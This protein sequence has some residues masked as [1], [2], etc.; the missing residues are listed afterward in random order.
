MKSETK[1]IDQEQRERA[2]EDLSQSYIIEAAAGT[3]K[4]TVLVTRIIYL[5][6]R[7]DAYLEE[8]VAITFTEKAAAELKVKLLQE[9]EKSLPSDPS[10]GEHQLISEAISDLE[11]MQVTTIHSFCG[12]LLRERPVEAGLD[13]NFEVADGL[14]ARLVQAEIWEDWFE[15]Q[16]DANDPA[17]RRAVL[18]GIKPDQI[19]EMSESL[20]E[21]RDVLK[22]LPSLQ[23]PEDL[24]KAIDQFINAFK[25]DVGSL[26]PLKQ[27]CR[28]T[29]DLAFLS[30]KELEE[31]LRKL[32][33]I[34]DREER[35]RFIFKEI[36]TAS[37]KKGNKTKWKPDHQLNKVRE[38]FSSI[39]ENLV[40][41]KA[42]IA[43]SI[44]TSLANRLTHYIEV[45]EQTKQERNFLD[46]QDLLIFTR[47]MLKEHPEVRRYFRG[48]YKFLLVDE[49][50]DTDP[51]QAEIVFFLSEEEKGKASEWKEVQ[52][53]S[54]R[55]F[56]VGD[57]KQ[58]IYRFRRADIEM[59][60]DAKAR[61]GQHR[62]LTISQNF[63]CAPSLVQVVNKIFADLIKI[64][65]DGQYQPEYVPL[66]FGRKKV[67]VP[68]ENGT[69][70]LYPPRKKEVVMSS[71][72]EC[73]LWESRCISSFIQKLVSEEKWQVW[74]NSDQSFRPIMFKDIAIL[75]RT[76]T[77]LN[78]LEE[79]LRSY[80]VDYRVVGGKHFYKRQEV[81]QLLAVLQAIDNPNDKV[82]LVAA[83]RSPFFGIS[84]EELFMF[85]AG[86]GSLNYLQET[87]GTALEQPFRLLRELHE[88]RNRASVSALLKRVYEETTGLVLFLLKP[89]GEQRVANLM[90]IGDVARAL[91][92]RGMLS[93][94]GFVRWLSERREEEAEEEEPPTLERGDNFVRLLTIH[95]AKGL[96][97]P[98]VILADLARKGDWREDFIVDR[99]G[100]RIAIK[101]GPKDS[102]FRTANYEELNQWEEKRGEAEERR[103]LYVGMTRA[104]DFLVLPVFWVKEK[105]DGKKDIPKSSFLNYLQPFLSEP[106]KVSLGEWDKDMMFYD[107]NQLELKPG[108]EAPFRF[109]LDI[110]KEVGEESRLSL[111]QRGKWKETQEEFKKHAGRDCP[112]TTAT[113]QVSEI[114][115]DDEWIMS[116][117]TKG[118][119]AI[120]G[121]LVH[122]LFEKL[123]W[124]KPEL[125]EKMA[126]IEGKD[127]GASGPMINRAGE[128]VK[129]A[130]RSPVLKRV[131]LSGDYQ[132]ESPF[133]Y[134]DRGT[135]VE[136]V[137][138][139]VFKEGDGL[140]VLD[141]K[142]DLVKKEDLNS[143]VEHYRP[144]VEVYSNAIKAIFGRLPREVIL[145]F[146][147]LM[148]PISIEVNE[149]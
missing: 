33:S 77:P 97:F 55:L 74:D 107:T 35:E 94:R 136:G 112:I 68:P 133:T 81:Q 5:I 60:E 80:E 93:F 87:Q 14:M 96:E 16:M 19:R 54:K 70:L 85:H 134:K 78:F 127:I 17:M 1:P 49:F 146:L 48:R 125:L 98:V 47:R 23:P 129:E 10:S 66:Y 2:V 45:Y 18:I 123:D 88:M 39:S 117:V 105:K 99:S 43:D 9:L 120:F 37:L 53:A 8:V 102:G 84:D 119:G 31:K 137:M 145:F 101:V 36:S 21:N 92:E 27:Y 124:G 75:I 90:K 86:G 79:A 83:L 50:Q 41:T 6:K 58:S 115:K 25:K 22:Y 113:E 42:L 149:S 141:F 52:V 64:P 142:T 13:P 51:L 110:E 108:E 139:V 7:G 91:D 20:L 114:E 28:D 34:P 3:G 4:T 95:K 82:A 135:I 56:I 11:R 89:Q 73:R 121:K 46:F 59:Y 116:A 69:V 148:E 71:T 138:D 57:P 104:R 126:E 122:R 128:M 26:H 144:Q 15:K 38:H 143:K 29:E 130:L 147:H 61:M 63:R 76:Y 40:K 72:K 132:K 24:E 65:E 12:S 62:L 109:P 140:V 118:E 67:T 106:D 111:S 30:I 131:I 103:L 44:M 32:E 100:E